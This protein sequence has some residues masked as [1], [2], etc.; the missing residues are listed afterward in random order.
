MGLS[1][2]RRPAVELQ[3]EA[4]AALA[5]FGERATRL[6]QLADLIVERAN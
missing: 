1:D 5:P 6:A 3:A 4:H 2:A